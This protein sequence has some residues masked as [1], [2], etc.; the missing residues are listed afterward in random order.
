MQVKNLINYLP[1]VKH[2]KLKANIKILIWHIGSRI[3]EKKTNLLVIEKK[4]KKIVFLKKNRKN[5]IK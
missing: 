5:K 4:I 3:F 1:R 2:A